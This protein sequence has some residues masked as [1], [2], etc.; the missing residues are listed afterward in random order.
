VKRDEKPAAPVEATGV[1]LGQVGDET[2]GGLALAPREGLELR[3]QL[4][5]REKGWNLD[6]HN[7]SIS[8]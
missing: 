8:S 2:S 5:V 1:E 7:Y 3:D 6:L 4:V